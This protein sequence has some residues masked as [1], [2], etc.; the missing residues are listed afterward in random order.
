MSIKE[1]F[2]WEIMSWLFKDPIKTVAWI[3]F[4]HVQ[5]NIKKWPK[6]VKLPQMRFFSWKTTNKMFMY[7]LAPF[8]VQNQKKKEKKNWSRSSYEDAPFWAKMTK[9]P[10]INFF[11]RKTINMISMSLFDPSIDA[12]FCVLN[13]PLGPNMIFLEKP[14][15]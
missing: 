1:T 9:L 11:F 7:L 3:N 10:Q 14:L 12:P 8:T 15:I 4:D 13:G 2:T 6:N 5:L